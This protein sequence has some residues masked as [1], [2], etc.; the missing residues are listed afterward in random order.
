[1]QHRK[2]TTVQGSRQQFI[3]KWHQ[4]PS[5][6]KG[7]RQQSTARSSPSGTGTWRSLFHAS[8]QWF[9]EM[10]FATW[11]NTVLQLSEP[12]RV[13]QGSMGRQA[14]WCIE[15]QS[16]RPRNSEWTGWLNRAVITDTA[17]S[18]S[19]IRP[20][21][22]AKGRT[23]KK[24]PQRLTLHVGTQFPRPPGPRIILSISGWYLS[25]STYSKDIGKGEQFLH[26]IIIHKKKDC[27]LFYLC[28]TFKVTQWAF[29]PWPI[30]TIKIVHIGPKPLIQTRP[31][32]FIEMCLPL[33]LQN[34]V[35]L[36]PLFC[37]SYF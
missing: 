34:W 14:V 37:S 33:T 26:R 29:K 20:R 30:S 5:L 3:R 18:K 19:P 8:V 13:Y 9:T 2:P 16:Y 1:M 35:R 7:S 31:L 28:W 6:T 32:N 22:I 10:F 4:F 17:K 36:R 23:H 15:N 12:V 21:C 27:I 24:K 25:N 11:N